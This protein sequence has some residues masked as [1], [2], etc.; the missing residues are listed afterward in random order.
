[1]VRCK[2]VSPSMYDQLLD[3]V[4]GSWQIP[5]PQEERRGIKVRNADRNGVTLAGRFIYG[6]LQDSKRLIGKATQP[7]GAGKDDGVEDARIKTG[8][9]AVEGTNLDREFHAALT[10]DLC[11]GLVAQ[12]MVSSAQPPLC[13]DGAGRVLGSL[14]NDAG[15]FRDRQ[16]AADVAKPKHGNDQTG[17]KA[18]LP[19]TLLESFRKR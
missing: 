6:L 7:Q 3:D 1:M 4:A 15:L 17:K 14:R 8:E 12:K 11:R 13:P 10:M 5:G 16:G 2:R 19:L 9:V 18:Q